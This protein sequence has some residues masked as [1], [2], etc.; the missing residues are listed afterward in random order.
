ARVTVAFR[1][2]VIRRMHARLTAERRHAKPRIV[3][4][5][6][7]PR[8]AARVARLGERVL[9]ERRVRLLGLRDAERRLR[10]ELE[11]G[12][13][14]RLQLA[15]LAGVMRGDDDF[16]EFRTKYVIG[17]R[18][19]SSTKAPDTRYR[20][21]TELTLRAGRPRWGST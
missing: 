5:R 14:D 8:G 20:A 19:A 4:E 15:Q 21:H 12:R 10:H 1:A 9:D 2:S 13:K 6:R 16:H 17:T 3:G 18:P 11:L 7:Q